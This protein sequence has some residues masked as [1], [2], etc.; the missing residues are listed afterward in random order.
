[1]SNPLEIV[2]HTNNTPRGKRATN[3]SKSDNKSQI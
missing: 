2:M 1:M 3:N